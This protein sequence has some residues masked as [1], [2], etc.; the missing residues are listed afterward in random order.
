MF[1][2]SI[3]FH[4]L[5]MSVTVATF[6]STWYQ[7]PYLSYIIAINVSDHLSK[8]IRVTKGTADVL[9]RR[10]SRVDL[11]D[12]SRIHNRDRFKTVRGVLCLTSDNDQGTLTSH[13]RIKDSNIDKVLLLV[14]RTVW[15]NKFYYFADYIIGIALNIRI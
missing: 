8:P 6:S 1:W 13:W 9:D 12:N 15:S 14:L 7:Y 10:F 11:T 4:Q 2:S 3:A 5:C